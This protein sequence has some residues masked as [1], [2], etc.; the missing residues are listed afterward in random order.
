MQF[1]SRL[2][3]M[4]RVLYVSH[5]WKKIV[6]TAIAFAICTNA[7]GYLI[8]LSNSPKYDSEIDAYQYVISNVQYRFSKLGFIGLKLPAGPFYYFYDASTRQL[9]K[10]L[11]STQD[12][13]ALKK[14]KRD[15]LSE[16]ERTTEW[17]GIATAVPG[18]AIGAA[19][20][21][22]AALDEPP[23][24]R[25]AR[26]GY[27]YFYVRVVAIL[28]AVGG[29]SGYAGYRLGY[30][31][32]HDYENPVFAKFIGESQ[33]YERIADEVLSCEAINTNKNEFSPYR[34]YLLDDPWQPNENSQLLTYM[35]V[36]AYSPAE[37][38]S[39]STVNP[40]GDILFKSEA[41]SA[42]QTMKSKNDLSQLKQAAA[43]EEN[44]VK[45]YQDT[46]RAEMQAT[47]DRLTK[48][49]MSDKAS[50]FSF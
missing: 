27:K 39:E 32:E 37:R 38:P 8:G 2:K 49:I 25:A 1:G 29:V 28:A 14:A 42:E 31:D 3:Q 47:C 33:I 36:E 13:L 10:E 35:R 7:I 45:K 22:K 44:A 15:R 23:I 4:G 30:I 41:K 48:H 11:R 26:G 18:G 50:I 24:L 46:L 17:I 19:T 9:R 34:E 40:I 6:V 20:S 21:L 43:L 12:L 5:Y 16:I